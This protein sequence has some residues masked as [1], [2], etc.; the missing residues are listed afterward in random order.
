VEHDYPG[1]FFLVTVYRGFTDSGCSKSFEKAIQSWPNPALA[2]PV[3]GTKL[4]GLLRPQNC[5]F[6]SSNSVRFGPDV[7]QAEAAKQ[8]ATFEEHISGVDGDAL[9]FLGPA[10]SL[11]YSP[12]SGDLYLDSTFRK[13]IERRSL[14]EIGQPLD[15][16]IPPATPQFLHKTAR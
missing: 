9:L 10:S 1:A 11:T 7:S 6:L 13:E 3:R 2:E 15:P 8:M 14:I 5:H 4:E 16:F 12:Q